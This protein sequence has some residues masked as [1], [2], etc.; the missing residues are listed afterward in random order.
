MIYRLL[1]RKRQRTVWHYSG[2]FYGMLLIGLSAI[3]EVSADASEVN[4]SRG[5]QD[6]KWD[7]L[8]KLRVYKKTSCTATLV[9]PNL[10]VS[11]AHCVFDRDS[12]AYVSP[13]KLLFYAG[14]KG[15]DIKAKVKIKRYT[16]P[17]KTFPTGQFTENAL[18]IDWVVL[19]LERPI[20]C[21]LGSFPLWDQQ[22]GAINKLITA[23][24]ASGNFTQLTQTDT[25]ESAV[26]RSDSTMWRLKNCALKK[27]DSGAPILV[28][29]KGQAEPYIAGV[30][31]AGANDSRG[32]FRVVAV[33]VEQFTN[34]VNNKAIS[35]KQP[36][37]L[38]LLWNVKIVFLRSLTASI[39]SF[40]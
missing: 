9:A 23:G 21:T 8:G 2:Y 10:I 3:I 22:V 18:L 6:I 40:H 24:Y 33:P 16:V 36:I 38:V 28:Q 35:C 17:S 27:G 31:S 12:N 5:S 37:F 7:R 1:Q 32:R 26:P 13:H 19:E 4:Q 14:L 20:G 39:P 15:N 30:I 29:I 11:A 25:C 34:T